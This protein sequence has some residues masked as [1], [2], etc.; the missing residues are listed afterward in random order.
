MSAVSGSTADP[1]TPSPSAPRLLLRTVRADAST[2]VLVAVLTLLVAVVAGL[3]PRAMDQ[4]AT[5][6]LHYSAAQLS[7]PL[8]DVKGALESFPGGPD[9]GSNADAQD[10]V[11]NIYGRLEAALDDWRSEQ[12]QPLRGILQDP[13]FVVRM[14]D[15]TAAQAPAGM[16]PPGNLWLRAAADPDYLEHIEIVEGD[17]PKAPA[18]DDS[19]GSAPMDI[20]LSVATAKT[21][22]LAVGDV[23]STDA[24]GSVRISG[25]FA[26]KDAD[27]DYWSNTPSVSDAAIFDDGNRTPD[28]TGTGFIAPTALAPIVDSGANLTTT[29]WYPIA[30]DAVTPENAQAVAAGIRGVNQNQLS[31]PSDLP[32]LTALVSMRSHLD[33]AI[34]ASLARVAAT[35]ALLS[36][37]ASGP[38]GVVIAVFALG[39]RAVVER[40]ASVIALASARG[41]SPRQLRGTAAL[42]GL[43]LGVPAALAGAAIAAVILPHAGGPGAWVVPLLFG[44][45]PAVLFAVLGGRRAFRTTRRDLS[46][47][48]RGGIRFAVAAGV[49]VLAGLAAFLLVRRGRISAPGV[50]PLLALT[51]LLLALAASVIALWVLPPALHAAAAIARR[52]RGLVGF[53]G[54]AR[55]LRDPALG[56]AAT[57]SV[58]VG[59]SVAVFSSVVLTT[60]DSA[61][62]TQAET[63]VGAD[64]RA[65]GTIFTAAQQRAVADIDDVAT[66]AP[67]AEAG[68]FSLGLNGRTE[69]ATVLLTDPASLHALRPEVPADLGTKVSGRVPIAISGDFSVPREVGDDL[70][71]GSTEVR[72]VGVVPVESGLPGQ[73]PW[74]LAD[75]A[76]AI[77]FGQSSFTPSTLLI[78]VRADAD[79]ARVATAVRKAVP[80][81]VVD[82]VDSQVAAVRAVPTAAGL[83]AT[84]IG[85]MLAGAL[86]AA[87][88]VFAGSVTASASR[89]ISIGM[90]RTMGMS[91]RESLGLV[92]WEIVPVVAVG[93]VVGTALGLA[94]PSLVIA[95]T[96]LSGFT[97]D[98]STVHVTPDPVQLALVL[99]VF[100]VVTGIATVLALLT[101]RRATPATTVKMGAE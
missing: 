6:D 78:D 29:M 22:R 56:V 21:M 82:D 42:E 41:A 14:A 17:A 57:L 61:A 20:V 60:V 26:L 77:D 52:G 27:G 85:A 98:T 69:D 46:A 62:Q 11:Q 70:M 84:L 44:C 58:V 91:P 65:S 12:R 99:L 75:Q 39:V 37:C 3:I 59:I 73:A 31:V 4:L 13:H 74:V 94:M 95:T 50:D 93:V 83:R 1:Q 64:V 53:I 90:L 15:R 18:A 47:R 10:E 40:R 72:V 19:G 88:A 45:V 36:I 89:S 71:L 79:A 63:I 87:V 92:A 8:R 16:S 38:I 9:P 67:I 101:A 96:D 7:D 76:F 25:L 49:I 2:S 54:S 80:A 66:V 32:G 35:V 55:S 24:L 48:A 97:G 43:V 68:R 34:D 5:S 33:E 86:L 100:L 23:L 28:Y 81:A 30:A 51:P